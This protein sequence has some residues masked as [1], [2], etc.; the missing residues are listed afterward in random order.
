MGRGILGKLDKLR[1]RIEG[2]PR[3][4]PEI[5]EEDI[6]EIIER[7]RRREGPALPEIELEIPLPKEKPLDF[8]RF[9]FEERL[10]KNALENF[11]ARFFIEFKNPLSQVASFLSSFPVAANIRSLLESAGMEMKAETFMALVASASFLASLV[12]LVSLAGTGL[13]NGDFSLVLLGI[14]S[15]VFVFIFVAFLLLLYPVMKAKDRASKIDRVLPFALRQISTQ[16]KAGVSFHKSIVSVAN[17][18]YGI[19]SQEFTKLLND[20]ERGLSTEEALSRLYSRMRSR[21]LRKAVT[22]IIRSLKTGGNLSQVISELAEDV[23]FETRMN[24]RDFTEKLNLINIL[25]IMVA[26]VA[27]VAA[28][29]M[30]AILQIPLFASA[31]PSY[32][33]YLAFVGI[34]GAMVLMLYVIKRMEPAAW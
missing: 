27:P 17:A 34:T 30:S 1:E 12:A 32:F 11:L 31:V 10:G 4:E 18:D 21:N 6:K 13:L 33:I 15:S 29:I 24:I 14:L 23:S 16:V 20:L 22:Q 7:M 19:L 3:E 28:T 5:E 2:K 8:K 25:L 26:V 9:S